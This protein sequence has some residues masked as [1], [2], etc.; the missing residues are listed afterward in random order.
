M[1]KEFGKEMSSLAV[2][3]AAMTLAL[4]VQ[5]D[6]TVSEDASILASSG[7]S[8]QETLDYWTREMIATAPAMVMVDTGLGGSDMANFDL[9]QKAV[10]GPEGKTSSG[11]ANSDSDD[12]HQQAFSGDWDSLANQDWGAIYTDDASYGNES[13]S[14]DT[15]GADNMAD[16]LAGTSGV[17]TSYVVNEKTAL[18]KLYPHRWMGKLTFKTPSGNASCSATVI[19]KNHIVTAAHCVYD[20]GSN[21]WNT[22]KV[23]TPAFRNGSA[24]Y[25]VFPTSQCRVLNHWVNLSGSYSINSW[26]RHDLAVCRMGKNAA[27]KTI[28]QAVGWSGYS[29]NHRYENLHFNS[30]YPARDYADALLPSPAQYLRSCTSES[31]KRTTDTLGMGCQYGRGISGGSWL[32]N[33]K[34]NY[35]DGHVNSVNSGLYIGQPNMY[36]ARFTSANIKALCNANGC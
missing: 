33:Y 36:G 6:V 1:K 14:Y 30:G 13:A 26:A 4:G 7:S 11:E 12:F 8:A 21:A 19:N 31:F 3:V 27:H 35:T 28:N 18:W 24:P 34:P 16:S 15:V 10:S 5:A 17:Y 32:R 20:T 23:F 9:D 2:S 25:G 22:H 29:W